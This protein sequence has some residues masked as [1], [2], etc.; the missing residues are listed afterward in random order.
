MSK[1]LSNNINIIE[2]S[3]SGSYQQF[4]FDADGLFVNRLF[5]TI[6]SNE[7]AGS[8]SGVTLRA[9]AADYFGNTS[10]LQS[11]FARV[12]YSIMDKY[13]I[14]ATVR[15]DVSSSFGNEN[16]YGIFPSAA[17][18]WKIH[19]DLNIDGID[20]LKLRVGYGITGN[21]Q[22]LGYGNFLRRKIWRYWN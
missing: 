3:L 10:E 14:T 20:N 12:N 4:G 19:E 21:Q 8:P 2:S 22:G 7:A 18:A 16:Q 17:V 9:A 13:L 6:S 1:E 15:A 11:Y 5:P